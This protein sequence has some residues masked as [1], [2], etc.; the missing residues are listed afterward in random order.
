MMETFGPGEG[1]TT[2]TGAAPSAQEDAALMPQVGLTST[3]LQLRGTCLDAAYVMTS[4][5]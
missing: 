5:L 1:E 3:R 4:W 2:Q